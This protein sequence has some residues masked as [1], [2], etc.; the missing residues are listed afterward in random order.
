MS[1]LLFRVE[2]RLAERRR[3]VDQ[4][5][6]PDTAKVSP[7]A[8]I[9]HALFLEPGAKDA[10]TSLGAGATGISARLRSISRKNNS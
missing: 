7:G 10:R 8:R 6:L 2:E 4:P 1:R 9:W 5:T 3:A